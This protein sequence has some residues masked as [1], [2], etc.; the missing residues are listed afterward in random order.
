MKITI[1]SRLNAS[2]ILNSP[3]SK[4][5]THIVSIGTKSWLERPPSGYMYHPAKKVR[6][7]FDDVTWSRKDPLYG[8]L[9][10]PSKTDVIKLIDFLKIV[11]QEDGDCLL[12]CFAGISRSTASAL[13][14]LSIKHGDGNEREAVLELMRISATSHPNMLIVRLSDEILGR[15]GKLERALEDF[16][17]GVY[18]K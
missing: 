15:A 1:M 7:I 18:G 14:L 6:L 5:I 9:T 11:V 2:R 17:N 4:N 3:K 13:V 16:Y 12:H 8:Y 10:A